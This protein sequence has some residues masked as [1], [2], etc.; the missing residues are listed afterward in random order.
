VTAKKTENFY[1]RDPRKALRG[2]MSLTPEECGVYNVLID[3]MYDTWRPLP[4]HSEDEK[5]WV[6][7]WI[8]AA[9]QRVN[10]IIRR[11]LD[12]GRIRLMEI[13][14]RQYLTD[15]AFEAEA[16]AVKRGLGR[17]NGAGNGGGNVA[18]NSGEV[19]ENSG[20]VGENLPLLDQ[21]SEENQRVIA[22]DKSKN[23]KK[24]RK[25]N[26]KEIPVARPMW[27]GDPDVRARIKNDPRF[28]EGWVLSWLDPSRLDGKCIV[29]ATHMAVPKLIACVHLTD[30]DIVAPP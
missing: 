22:L 27:G 9:P 24:S 18:E 4:F 5:R 30:F 3:L 21:H 10:P 7:R 17:M 13:D 2:M 1:R 14:G 19:G 6:V 23:K 26:T 20:E 28:G 29:A 8:N 15:D 11:L 12:K 25:E 16:K